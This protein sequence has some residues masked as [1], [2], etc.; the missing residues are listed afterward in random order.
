M[1]CPLL[2]ESN[3]SCVNFQHHYHLLR[4]KVGMMPFH[5]LCYW[6]PRY[7]YCL[8]LV[9]AENHL[10]SKICMIQMLS[11]M[12]ICIHFI[13]LI[14]SHNLY[15]KPTLWELKESGGSEGLPVKE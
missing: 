1:E 11:N 6:I 3:E 15:T 4:I 10:N 7:Q 2:L 5:L 8:V 13:L 9:V 12:Q 14:L